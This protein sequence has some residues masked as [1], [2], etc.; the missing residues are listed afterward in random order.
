MTTALSAKGRKFIYAH[1]GCPLRA[2]RDPVGIWTIGPGLTAATGLITPKAGMEIT[3]EQADR[4]FDQVMARTHGPRVERMLGANAPQNA[5]DGGMSFDFN[6]GGIDTASWV[7]SWLAGQWAEVKRRLSLWCKAGGRV[8]PGL[9]RRRKEEGDI[10]IDGVYPAGIEEVARA[11]PSREWAAFVVTV[12][13]EEI[14]TVRAGLLELGYNPGSMRGSVR[15]LAVFEFQQANG[16]TVDGKI[17]RAT[18]ATLQRAV[19]RRRQDAALTTV[20]KVAV[21]TGIAA[22]GATEVTQQGMDAAAG[23]NGA[24]VVTTAIGSGVILAL[25]VGA[26]V[27]VGFLVYRYRGAIF[28][29]RRTRVQKQAGG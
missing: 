24:D 22:G 19:E 4:L 25:V 23:T 6:T 17:G 10:I 12:S 29:T 7:A 28:G 2:Y 15:Y 11:A 27:V 9:V 20:V 8:L 18:M 1:E 14:E 21:P 5:K 3:Q 26:L 13:A 16:L